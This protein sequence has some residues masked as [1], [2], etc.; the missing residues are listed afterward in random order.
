MGKKIEHNHLLINAKIKNYP[1]SSH[2]NNFQSLDE[3]KKLL[4][5][6][7]HFIPHVYFNNQPENEIF[8]IHRVDYDCDNPIRKYIRELV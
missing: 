8:I 6:E 5:K 7:I 4:N 3:I 2:K 1:T